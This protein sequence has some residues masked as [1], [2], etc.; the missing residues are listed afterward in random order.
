[1]R[2]WPDDGTGTAVPEADVEAVV[3]WGRF[4]D[5][6]EALQQLE[7]ALP[8]L[9]RGVDYR[10]LLLALHG[11]WST[12]RSSAGIVRSSCRNASS[13]SVKRPQ[14]TTASTSASGTVALVPSSG[15]PRTAAPYPRPFPSALEDVT[16][17][18]TGG[19]RSDQGG[20]MPSS[21]RYGGSRPADPDVRRRRRKE[22]RR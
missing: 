7:H 10:P 14:A 9:E 11:R 6:D 4:T 8:A 19:H 3:A 12:P 13:A 2:G 17:G 16:G 15:Q 18:V 22:D 21:T 1:M 20:P 5:S